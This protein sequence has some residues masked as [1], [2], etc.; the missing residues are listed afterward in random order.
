MKSARSLFLLALVLASL[1]ALSA[2]YYYRENAQE[3]LVSAFTKP[4]SSPIPY[5]IGDIDPRFK[6]S[7]SEV[8][9]E[10]ASA[11]KLWNTAYDSP[12]FVYEPDNPKALPITF[13]Y[14]RRQQTIT[15]GNEI[16]S[17][18]ASQQQARTDIETARAAYEQNALTYSNHV[19]QFN[20]DSKAYAA[21]VARVN[22]HGGA[23]QT[24]YA[25]LQAEKASLESRQQQLKQEGAALSTEAK[26]LSSMI[27]AYNAKVSDIN[28]IVDTFNAQSGGDFEEGLYVQDKYGKRIYIYAYKTRSELMHTLAHELGHALGLDHND[29][30]ESIMFAYNKNSVELSTEDLSALKTVCN[31]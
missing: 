24:Q 16:T 4:C 7:K 6:L 27:E 2:L 15:V 31:K 22:A 21:E 20:A 28:K 23:T 13:V 10:V 12:L 17:V 19:D 5:T 18:E 9:A 3:L 29:N 14:D 25:R 11:A 1:S 8:I 30:P 26:A